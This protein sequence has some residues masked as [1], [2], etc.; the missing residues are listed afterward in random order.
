MNLLAMGLTSK[1]TRGSH[2]IPLRTMALATCIFLDLVLC[3]PNNIGMKSSDPMLST[4]T[5][6]EGEPVTVQ[7]QIRNIPSGLH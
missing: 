6:I 3:I 1:S 7:S 2:G 5:S 4:I